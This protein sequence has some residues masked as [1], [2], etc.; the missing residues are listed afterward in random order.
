MK[1]PKFLASTE[2]FRAIPFEILREGQN[3]KVNKNM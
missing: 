3:G 2:M 1:T